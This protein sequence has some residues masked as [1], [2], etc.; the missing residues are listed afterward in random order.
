[1]HRLLCTPFIVL[2][3][4]SLFGLL[5]S[6]SVT[7]AQHHPLR[8]NEPLDRSH[9]LEPVFEA[10]VEQALTEFRSGYTASAFD[11]ANFSDDAASFSAQLHSIDLFRSLAAYLHGRD[12]AA[13][14][15]DDNVLRNSAS[16]SRTHTQAALLSA[17]EFFAHQPLRKADVEAALGLLMAIS[18]ANASN[19]DATSEVS[20]W[21]SEA[22]G[23]LGQYDQA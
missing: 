6:A 20:F 3:V 11:S 12:R 10:R 16:I 2:R 5:L 23:A 4:F 13:Q 14:A 21:C 22:F 19:A 9:A 7:F 1:M 8:E 17:L 18:D 15:S